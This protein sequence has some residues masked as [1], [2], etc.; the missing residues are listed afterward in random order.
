MNDSD[1]NLITSMVDGQL[2]PAEQEEAFARM[3][4]EPALRAAYE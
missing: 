1:I 2:S 3:Q 4:A